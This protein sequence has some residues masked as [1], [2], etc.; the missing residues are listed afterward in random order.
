M[1]KRY[2]GSCDDRRVTAQ[3]PELVAEGR[4]ALRRGDAAGARALRTR[5]TGPA[6]GDVIEGLARASYLELDFAA[7]IEGWERAYAAYRDAG[8][9]VGAVRV[10]RT[11]AYMYGAIVGDGAVMGGWLAR[12]QTLLGGDGE[13][14]RSAAGWRST[15]A[16]SR[17]TARARRRSSAR[18]STSARRFGD[19]DLEFVDARLPRRQPRPRR[20][21]RG[22]HGAPRR[23]ARRGG[24][25]RGRRLLR[26]A[27]RSSASCSRRAS[28]PTTSPAPTSGSGSARRSP[29]GASFRRSRRSAARTTAA[30][31][32]RPA[33][34][35]RPTPR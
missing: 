18:R 17:A 14:R 11:L 33:A 16:C 27:R 15:S 24:G 9:Q 1:R 10:A 21:H 19:T 26:A 8:D 34:G 13:S 4:A 35:P 2:T 28:T 29:S 5:P 12:A 30:S 7:A 23:G 25:Q 22:G 31:S 6:S 3:V 32:P 20:P